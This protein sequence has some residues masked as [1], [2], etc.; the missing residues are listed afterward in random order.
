MSKEGYKP[1]AEDIHP[2]LPLVEPP[3]R[4]NIIG[5]VKAEYCK[6]TVRQGLLQRTHRR[7][8]RNKGLRV[9][10][11]WIIGMNVGELPP[12]VDDL[13]RDGILA[14]VAKRRQNPLPGPAVVWAL[15]G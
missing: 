15:H 1:A 14:R 10:P 12:P 5:V 7:M 6:K 13:L 11:R 8:S 2:T 3:D 9:I 4:A